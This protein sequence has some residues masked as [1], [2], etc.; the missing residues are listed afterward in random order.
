M[1][2]ASHLLAA[3]GLTLAAALASS[4]AQTKRVA[5]PAPPKAVTTAAGVYTAAQ[6]ARGEQTY[7]NLCV[8]CHPPGTY[9]TQMFRSKWNLSLLSRLYDLVSNTMPKNEPGMLEPDEYAQVI[10][11]L[12][13]INGAPA[14]K[15]PLPPDVKELIKIRILMPAAGK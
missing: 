11:Y 1:V 6:A 12:L 14:G 4:A 5:K 13:K 9:T 8:S 10:A 3:A 2:N 15:T 7:M